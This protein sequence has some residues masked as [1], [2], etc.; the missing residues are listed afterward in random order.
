MGSFL[1]AKS[2]QAGLSLVEASI[3]TS[4]PSNVVNYNGTV[5]CFGRSARGGEIFVGKIVAGYCNYPINGL[6]DRASNYKVMTTDQRI[7]WLR[8]PVEINQSSRLLS[9][10]SAITIGSRT[11]KGVCGV[12]YRNEDHVGELIAGRG[13]YICRIGYGGSAVQFGE[14]EFDIALFYKAYM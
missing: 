5:A 12:N 11:T 7:F 14:G 1:T 10:M 9:P 8:D 2:A 13:S 3:G 6:E 4:L